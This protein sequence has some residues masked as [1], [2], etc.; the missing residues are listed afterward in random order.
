MLIA[1]RLR[2]R[3]FGMLKSPL[4]DGEDVLGAIQ[5]SFGLFG[6]D[7]FKRCSTW[8]GIRIA[9]RDI[10]EVEFTS[11]FLKDTILIQGFYHLKKRMRT[12]DVESLAEA[13]SLEGLFSGLLGSKTR[14]VKPAVKRVSGPR[15]IVFRLSE[16]VKKPVR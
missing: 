3:I 14:R 13:K 7:D 11:M 15:Q 2:S 10:E 4:E 9:C 6:R 1:G 16:P 8:E 5:R 12:D